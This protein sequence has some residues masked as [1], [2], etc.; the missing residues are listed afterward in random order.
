MW[1]WKV[2]RRFS[3]STRRGR[4][5]SSAASISPRFSRSSGGIGVEAEG[6]VD[7][8]FVGDR[9]GSDVGAEPC[10]P[11]SKRYSLRVSPC[12][13]ARWRRATL[14]SLLPVKYCSAKGNS[15]LVDGAEVALQ[16]VLE[17][18]R[19]LGFAVGEDLLDAGHARRSAAVSAGGL[20]GGDQEIEVVDGFLGAPVGTGDGGR[21]DVRDGR[22]ERVEDRLGDGGDLA[23]PEAA[24]DSVSRGDGRRGSSR[25]VF[26]P[27]PGR[28]ATLPASQAS[29]ER[30]DRADAELLVERLD[31]FRAEALDLEELEDGVGEFGRSF[32]WNSS[33]PVVASSWSLSGGRRRCP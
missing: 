32:S 23:E 13:R 29:L 14:C 19:G 11:G 27:K 17:A 3:S 21:G 15:A 10:R 12:S 16:S 20:R 2:P 30:L 24:G 33:S 9:R 22:A 25:S 18:D 8:G 31:L 4:S 6:A 26:F 28:A 7:V 1:L 5:P